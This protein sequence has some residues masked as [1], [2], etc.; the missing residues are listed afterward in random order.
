MYGEILSILTIDRLPSRKMS[1][2]L[3]VNVS[4]ENKSKS[5]HR[6]SFDLVE[7]VQWYPKVKLI[8]MGLPIEKSY[9]SF[10]VCFFSISFQTMKERERHGP[11]SWL[12]FQEPRPCGSTRG[13]KLELSLFV[14]IYRFLVNLGR[15]PIYSSNLQI[16]VNIFFINSK[17]RLINLFCVNLFQI[18]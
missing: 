7:Q 13:T 15:K 6:R 11:L 1:K 14:Q 17:T 16:N 5:H 10:Q 8:F 12:S 2:L 3:K 4:I 18:S 9:F